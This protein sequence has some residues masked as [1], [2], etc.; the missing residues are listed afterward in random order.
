MTDLI[1]DMEAESAAAHEQGDNSSL[2]E[3]GMK[4]LA[5]ETSIAD[6]TEVMKEKK[7]DLDALMTGAIPKALDLAGIPGFEF[8]DADGEIHRIRKDLLVTASLKNA[9]DLDAAIQYLEANGMG[10][11]VSVKL[12]LDFVESEREFAEGVAQSLSEGVMGQ[13]L[14]PTIDR[15]VNP[16]T[17]RAFVKRKMQEA[18]GFDPEIVGAEAFPRAK[19]VR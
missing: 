7:R 12:T 1:E 5:L 19:F 16:S 2:A 17:L 4:A 15:T 3:L 9:P 11:G 13:G 10:G 8:E 6:L 14:E 18:D